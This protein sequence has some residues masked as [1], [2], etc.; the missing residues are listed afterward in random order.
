MSDSKMSMILFSYIPLLEGEA[1]I[2][3]ENP[4]FDEISRM[5]ES[6]PSGAA[7]ACIWVNDP[8]NHKKISPILL[9]DKAK[10]IVAHLN[11]WTEEKPTDWF[12]LHIKEK[13][14]K[15]VIAL[16]PRIDRSLQRHKIAYQLRKSKS[17]IQSIIYG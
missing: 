7:E 4:E 3:I 12:N 8:D 1:G 17:Y 6:V 11:R 10:E 14:G 13:Y 2:T 15:Y 5:M 9:Y 16:I